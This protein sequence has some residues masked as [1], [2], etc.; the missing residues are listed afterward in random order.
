MFTPASD[1]CPSIKRFLLFAVLVYNT[2][3]FGQIK[4]SGKVVNSAGHPMGYASVELFKDSTAVQAV[5]TDSAGVYQM[6]VRSGRY[7]QNCRYAGSLQKGQAVDIVRDTVINIVFVKQVT[8]EEV[9]V[10]SKKPLIER[11]IDRY[12]F[13]VENSIVSTGSDAL[14]ALS[15]TPG[16]RINHNQI[17]LVGKSVVS[18]LIDDRLLQLSSDDLSNYLKSIPSDNIQKIEGITNPPSKYEAQGNSG[19]INI[20]MKKTNRQG[21][22]GSVRSAYAQTAYYPLSSGGGNFNYKAKKTSFYANASAV[23]GHAGPVETETIHYAQQTWVTEDKRKDN[24][25][26]LNGKA[27]IEHEIN[28]NIKAGLS[29]ASGIGDFG[30]SENITTAIYNRRIQVTNATFRSW[31]INW[32]KTWFGV[33]KLS[34]FLGLLFSSFSTKLIYS[35][36]MVSKFVFLGIYWRTKPLRFSFAPLSQLW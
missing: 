1:V 20:V 27:G 8:L 35:S 10:S 9:V 32:L 6:S 24:N 31:F 15:K 23:Y 2:D 12:I 3:A 7:Y 36:V 29:Y 25:K 13:N 16:V 5:L 26:S 30:I 17:S 11:K 22:Y 18:V 33:S 19:L 34:L 21:Y 14:A 4:I 28:K